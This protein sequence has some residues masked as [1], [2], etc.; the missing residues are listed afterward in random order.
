MKEKQS[1]PYEFERI[2]RLFY[3]VISFNIKHPCTKHTRPYS[4][5]LLM[6]IHSIVE[7]APWLWKWW[8]WWAWRAKKTFRTFQKQS[9]RKKTQQQHIQYKSARDWD[10]LQPKVVINIYL[11][12]FNSTVWLLHFVAEC[13]ISNNI[14]HHT[15]II[16][17]LCVRRVRHG[18]SVFEFKFRLC[19]K[20]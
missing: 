16:H 11:T 15:M 12:S 7:S 6:H 17:F 20:R 2:D 14:Q 4:L 8:Q 13:Q 3:S 19:Q 18:I 9:N 5:S 10:G 1:T